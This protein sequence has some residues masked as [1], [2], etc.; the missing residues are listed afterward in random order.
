[1]EIEV[2]KEKIRKKILEEN[3]FHMIILLEEKKIDPIIPYKEM[4]V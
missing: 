2:Q 1:M 3:L 4:Y